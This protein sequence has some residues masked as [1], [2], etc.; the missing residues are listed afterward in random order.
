MCG[1]SK[2]SIDEIKKGIKIC[3]FKSSEM[4]I[5]EKNTRDTRVL[6]DSHNKI[7]L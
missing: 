4:G 3:L 6:S 1:F 5:G 7:V 2:K